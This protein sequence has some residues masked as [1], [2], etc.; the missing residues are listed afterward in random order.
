MVGRAPLLAALDGLLDQSVAGTGRTVLLAGEAG[1]GKT[2]L[3]HEAKRRAGDLGMAILEGHCFE[4][5]RTVPYSPVLD[6]LRALLAGRAADDIASLL[7]PAA[8]ELANLLPELAEPLTR[9]VRSPAVDPQPAK[10]RLFEAVT[11]LLLG[12]GAPRPLLVVVEDLHWSDDVSLELLLQVARR[13][14]NARVLVLLTYRNEEVGASL[15]HFLADLDRERLGIELNVPRLGPADV[16]AMVRSIFGLSRPAPAEL[17]HV[18]FALSEG[19]PFF[20]EEL[21]KSLLTSG[22]L[23]YAEGALGHRPSHEWRVPRTVEDAVRRRSAALPW[24]ARRVLTLAAVIG[25]RF[26]FPLLKELAG[27]SDGELLK[28]IKAL[29]AAQL[30]VEESADRFAFRHALTREAIYLQLLL[31]ERQALHSAIAVAIERL[32]APEL[33]KHFEALAYHTYVGGDWET[34]LLYAERAGDHAQAVHAPRAAVEQFTHETA[35]AEVRSAGDQAAEWQSLLDLGS[36]W[37]ERDYELS[38]DYY[39]RALDLASKIGDQVTLAH[40]LNRLANWHLNCEQPRQARL[41]HDQALHIFEGGDNRDGIAETLGFLGMANALSGDLVQGAACYQRAIP[42]LRDVGDRQSLAYCQAALILCG[43]NYATDTMVPG[44]TLAETARYG[45]EGLQIAR[46]IGWR[47]GESFVLFNLAF[48]YTIQGEYVRAWVTARASLEIAEEIEHRQWAVGAHWALGALCL[49]RLDPI[50]AR[51]HLAQALAMGMEIGS[52]NWV[53]SSA[54]LLA[55]AHLAQGDAALA[56][57]VLDAAIGWDAP[58]ET[59]GQ[60]LV[61]CARADVALARGDPAAA[62]S[63]V[64]RLLDSAA[65]VAN[66]TGPLRLLRLRG[67]ALAAAGSPEATAALEETVRQARAQGARPQLWR[68]HVAL[69]L[70][71]SAQRRRHDAEREF[72]AGRAVVQELAAGLD[73]LQREQFMRAARAVIPPPPRLTGKRAAKHAFGGLTEREREVA[74]LIGRGKTNREIAA[75]LFVGEGTI[76]THIKHVFAKLGCSSRSQIAAWAVEKGVV[77]SG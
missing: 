15:S 8:P 27:L 73:E 46:D 3:A 6:L 7:G 66:G 32:Y 77:A 52:R 30:V 48:C 59:L 49:D 57:A 38:G 21:L 34:A 31:R 37:T 26:D 51:E 12:L 44:L 35:L 23:G 56:E 69:G 42:I 33:A 64:D 47:A 61:W 54:G 1:I 41:Y 50:A 70:H 19:N 55:S 53:C 75:A 18:L 4:P 65:T 74:A 11:Q 39:Q 62:L 10:R 29:I 40:S 43:P 24:A 67:A 9:G 76:A 5:D 71:H 2:R 13:T 14:V 60:R 17:L 72:V 63:I 68:A 22:D 20:V 16:D 45:E 25:Q 28:H 36:L 58:A